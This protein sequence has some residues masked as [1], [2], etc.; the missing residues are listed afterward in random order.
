VCVLSRIYLA[1][2]GTA[3]GWSACQVRFRWHG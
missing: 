1:S 3:N 2:P